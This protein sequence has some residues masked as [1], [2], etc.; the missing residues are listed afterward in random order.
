MADNRQDDGGG[1][2]RRKRQQEKQQLA[3]LNQIENV[4]R[5]NVDVCNNSGIR[6]EGG[7]IPSVSAKRVFSSFVTNSVC[8]MAQKRRRRSV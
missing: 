5:G 2:A 7:R 8:A 6:S 3:K 4:V 1:D